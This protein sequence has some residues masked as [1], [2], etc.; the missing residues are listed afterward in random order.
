M[1]RNQDNFAGIADM[2]SYP[3]MDE[4]VKSSYANSDDVNLK[5]GENDDDYDDKN[6]R[7]RYDRRRR[8]SNSRRD[9]RSSSRSRRRSDSRDR[10]DSRGRRNRRRSKSRDDDDN[11]KYLGSDVGIYFGY[12]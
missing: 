4:N 2:A 5:S 10:S 11:Q 3:V 9:S 8:D 12:F 7:R 6:S 1:P